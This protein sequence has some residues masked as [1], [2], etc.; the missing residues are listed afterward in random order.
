LVA[1]AAVVAVVVAV[2]ALDHGPSTPQAGAAGPAPTATAPAPGSGPQ[3]GS[4]SP[5]AVAPDSL[6]ALR[7]QVATSQALSADQR[8]QLLSALD[9]IAH[10]LAE[11]NQGDAA[12]SLHDAQKYL[13]RLAAHGNLDPATASAWQS[14]LTQLSSSVH[15]DNG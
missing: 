15:G 11:G 2:V 4:S 3:A 1:L 6:T 9:D 12:H 13:H 10:A 5:S 7:A 8:D 14:T